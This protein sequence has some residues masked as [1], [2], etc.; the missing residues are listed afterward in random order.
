[1]IQG[2]D[3]QCVVYLKNEKE[4]HAAL[5]HETRGMKVPEEFQRQEPESKTPRFPWSQFG[6]IFCR[7]ICVSFRSNFAETWNK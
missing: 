4:I 2:L 7:W 6:E 5:L 1:M 3:N